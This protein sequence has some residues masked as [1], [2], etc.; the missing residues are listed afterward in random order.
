MSTTRRPGYFDVVTADDLRQAIATLRLDR[1]SD[2]AECEHLS[3]D[4]RELLRW[5]AHELATALL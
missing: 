5:A 3:D 1:L 2:L 4:A